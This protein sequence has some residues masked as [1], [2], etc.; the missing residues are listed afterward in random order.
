MLKKRTDS[1][2]NVLTPPQSAIMNSGPKRL[3]VVNFSCL[4]NPERVEVCDCP[5]SLEPIFMPTYSVVYIVEEF[6]I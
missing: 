6:L 1:K 5:F 4:V 2:C 3:V